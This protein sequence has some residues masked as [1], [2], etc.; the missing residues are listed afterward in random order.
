MKILPIII[1]TVVLF[2]F[3]FFLSDAK[4]QTFNYFN[5]R[6][7]ISEYEL[8]DESYAIIETVDGFVLPGNSLVINANI[9]WWEEKLIKLDQHGIV[10]YIK[11][12]GE[13]S[14]DYFFSSNPR[15]LI[16][17][18]DRLYAVAKRRTPTSNW[19]HDEGTLIYLDENLD[20]LWSRRYGECIEPFDTAYL[21]TCLQ[22]INQNELIIAGGWKPYGLASHVYLL[23]VDS[24]GN[25]IWDK[26][27]NY[28]NDYIDGH[29]IVQTTD[30]GF[31]IGC[32]KQTPGYPYTVDPIIIKTD[33]LGNQKWT[34]NLGGP[35]KDFNALV[36]LAID[37]N[38]LVGTSYADSML[39]PDIPLSRINIIKLDN[40]GTILWNKKFGS[41]KPNNYLRNIRVL[42][43][44]CIIAT[45]ALRKY[46]PEPDW[47]GWIL[48][49][50]SDGDSLWYREY[51]NLPGQESKNY[52]Y[53]VIETSD[54]GLIACGYVN[55][56]LPD[57]GSTDTWVIKLDSIGCDS[58]GC[59]TTVGI[60]EEHGSMEAWGHGGLIIWPNPARDQIH[61]RFYMD[62]GRFYKDFR[63]EIYDIFGRNVKEI[64]VPD[65]QD[66][67]Q[68][69]V[70]GYPRGMYLA[71]LKERQIIKANTKFII[72]K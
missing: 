65:K 39:T 26:S 36:S 40:E 68:I 48:K 37:G 15:C 24:I 63:L 72:V 33:S 56:Y 17:E 21:F 3:I 69:N 18:N 51:Y 20:T 43:D 28:Y 11:T 46:N 2:V 7:D 52:L 61:V 60:A 57:T 42:N 38:I 54:N 29:S 59:D 45:G 30:L 58:A 5:Y 6:Y 66:E 50:D 19:V 22:K 44:G 25:K 1:K 9:Y 32:F 35:F 49:I 27:F 67:V 16:E 62:D 41:S 53:D 47:V 55:P 10:Q 8:Q 34:K 23:K 4:T 71:V 14:I 64:K 31:I 70:E 13:D 12:Y